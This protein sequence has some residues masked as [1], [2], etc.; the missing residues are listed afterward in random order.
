MAVKYYRVDKTIKQL[1][2]EIVSDFKYFKG[3]RE[4]I[5]SYIMDLGEKMQ[6]MSS[7]GKMDHNI[8]YGCVSKVWV[9]SVKQEGRVIYEGDSDASITKGLLSMVIKVFSKQDLDDIIEA[10]LY[11]IQEIG[12]L[13]LIGQQ[14]SFGL[15]NVIKKMKMIAVSHKSRTRG[16]RRKRLIAV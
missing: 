7:L 16:R 15:A 11:F 14:R 2:D 5:L 9:S 10:D 3:D 12:L 4:A 1:Q 13:N 6:P 8:V